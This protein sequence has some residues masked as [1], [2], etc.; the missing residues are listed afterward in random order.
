[1]AMA[2]PAERLR[3]A[4]DL[5][6]TGVDLMRENLRRRHPLASDEEIAEL[7]RAWLRRRPPD[8]P[9]RL[10]PLSRR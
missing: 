2:T 3:I 7:L 4:L 6:D 10:R 5:A 9:D 8:S 1:M